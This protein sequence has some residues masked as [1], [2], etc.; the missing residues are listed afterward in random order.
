MFNIKPFSLEETNTFVTEKKI[1]F[2]SNGI[3]LNGTVYIPAGAS[4]KKRVPAMV[5]CHGYG[6]KQ[7]AFE[8]SARELVAK[9]VATLTFDFRGHGESGGL[10]DDSVVDD[11]IDAWE[12]LQNQPEVDR[13]R[14]GL[15]GHSMGAFSAILA[16]GKLKNAI[17]LVALACPG[18]V[19]NAVARNPRH[20]ARPGLVFVAK[21]IFKIVNYVH[22]LKVKVDWRKFIEFWPKMKPSESLVELKSCSKLFVFCLKDLASPYQNF[23]PAYAMA[24]EPKQVMIAQGHHNTAMET[25]YVREQWIK[26]VINKLHGNAVK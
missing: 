24:S 21:S 4:S 26:W 8:I 25:G 19:T 2:G 11:V 1:T 10:L 20:F 13:K 6:N 17:V 22:K 7:T 14:M 16:A 18:E 9:G 23:L 3:K 12:Y 15:V 5:M